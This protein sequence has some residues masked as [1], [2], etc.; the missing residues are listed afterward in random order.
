MKMKPIS[1]LLGI[2]LLSIS[3]SVLAADADLTGAKPG[4]WTMDLDAA[5]KLAKSE[6]LPILLNFSGSDWCGWCKLME[7]GVFSQKTWKDYAKEN[8]LMVVIDFPKDDTIV[9]KKYLKRNEELKAQFAVEGFPTFV[10]LDDDAQ[11]E[12]G[13]LGA[14]RDKTPE[15]FIAVINKLSRYRATQLA[16]YADSLKPKDKAAYLKI[17]NQI[18]GTAKQIA[19]QKKA[20][21]DAMQ[22]IQKLEEKLSD[23]QS[24]AQDFR[25]SQ[26]DGDALKQYKSMKAE[27]DAAEKKLEDWIKTEPERTEENG[28]KYQDM[29]STLQKF[30]EKLSQY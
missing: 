7:K 3:S 17:A 21:K 18:P 23:Q 9:P 26:L 14:G 10:L 16:K 27:T 5:K 28:K 13:R 1:V 30:S 20:I 2:L 8:I 24:S 19:Q 11:T 12:L 22:N 6:Q 15:S 29:I 4:K 25:A